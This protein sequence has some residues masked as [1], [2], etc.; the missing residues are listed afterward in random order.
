MILPQERKK[1]TLEVILFG[2][3]QSFGLDASGYILASCFLADQ[4][5]RSR[6]AV[7]KIRAPT[8]YTWYPDSLENTARLCLVNSHLRVVAADCR[9]QNQ[10]V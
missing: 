4:R 3:I 1:R 6:Q 2:N 5:S 10:R 7:A 9:R 8:T